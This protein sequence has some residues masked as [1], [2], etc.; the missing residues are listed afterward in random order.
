MAPYLETLPLHKS[1]QTIQR[2]VTGAIIIKLQVVPTLELISA[3]LFQGKEME[4]IQPD[5]LRTK[6]KEDLKAS[7][8]KYK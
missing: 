6:I 8:N 1:Q 5:W 2:E 3:I 4:I 7:I